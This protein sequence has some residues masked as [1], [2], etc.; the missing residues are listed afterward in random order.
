MKNANTQD[1]VFTIPAGMQV[2]VVDD[3]D[4]V[5]STAGMLLESLG[6]VV[7]TAENGDAGLLKIS[8]GLQ[9]DMILLDINMP[10]ISGDQFMQELQ[11]REIEVP[12]ILCSGYTEFDEHSYAGFHNM[13]GFLAK[14]Y[15]R[16]ELEQ[17]VLKCIHTELEA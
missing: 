15:T 4:M 14:P 1:N 7:E 13:R 3:E 16:R 17:T 10:G 5:R 11:A 6:C 8:A 2:L 9:V 12:I